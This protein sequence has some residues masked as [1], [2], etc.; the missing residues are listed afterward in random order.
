MSNSKLPQITAEK[1]IKIL[2]KE[3][4][5]FVRQRGS[6][7]FYEKT[8]EG[9]RV[10]IPIPVHPGRALKRGTLH[11]ILKKAQVSREILLRSLSK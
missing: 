7:R 6:H 8:I 4:F 5:E 11:H 1:L 3:G 2:E 10:V 9:E